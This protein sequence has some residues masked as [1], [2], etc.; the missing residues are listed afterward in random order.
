MYVK[1]MD[2]SSY[3]LR[4][5]EGNVLTPYWRIYY[6]TKEGFIKWE[7]INYPR[8]DAR[9][10]IRAEEILAFEAK[11]RLQPI[12]IRAGL[13]FL[14]QEPK[15]PWLSLKEIK[16]MD[17]PPG[18]P[19]YT[20]DYKWE[21]RP[22]A[23]VERDYTDL[24]YKKW[25]PSAYEGRRDVFGWTKPAKKM[26]ETDLLQKQIADLQKQVEVR[27]KNEAFLKD[28]LNKQE[29]GENVGNV[30]VEGQ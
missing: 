26:T 4:D 29:K 12:E 21:D 17:V 7:T 20:S 14:Q 19:E 27:T 24:F 6:E 25:R 22:G 8:G 15:G 5:A 2:F 9:A 11:Y 30:A 3:P 18:N 16:G 13:T 10:D 28:L 1:D 23:W